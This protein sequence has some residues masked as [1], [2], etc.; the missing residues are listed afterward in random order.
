MKKITLLLLAAMLLPIT[1][2][3]TYGQNNKVDKLVVSSTPIKN[4]SEAPNPPQFWPSAEEVQIEDFY[5]AIQSEYGEQAAIYYML[6]PATPPTSATTVRTNGTRCDGGSGY[7]LVMVKGP[8][9]HTI[10]AVTEVNGALSE[11]A[12]ITYNTYAIGDWHLVTNNQELFVDHYE[13]IIINDEYDKAVGS[14]DAANRCFNAV[15]CEGNVIFD[16]TPTKETATVN[17]SDVKIFRMEYDH[18]TGDW[19]EGYLKDTEG[20]YYC[21]VGPLADPTDDSPIPG[22]ENQ[23]DFVWMYNGGHTGYVYLENNNADI[24][25]NTAD[26]V[27][28]SHNWNYPQDDHH[29]R[30]RLYYR[31]QGV[32]LAFMEAGQRGYYYTISDELLAVKCVTDDNNNAYLFCKDDGPSISATENTNDYEDY[33]V[34][35]TDFSGDWDQSNWIGL[36]FNNVNDNELA[37]IKDCE[38]KRLKA[39]TITVFHRRTYSYNSN[40]FVYDMKLSKLET[41]SDQVTAYNPNLYCPANFLTSNLEGNAT[42]SGSYADTHYFFMNPKLQE[43]CEV[44]FAVWDGNN[45]VLPA[46]DGTN[47][48]TGIQGALL[49]NFMF[50]KMNVEDPTTGETHSLYDDLVVGQAYRFQAIVQRSTSQ[51]GVGFKEDTV[52]PGEYDP[53]PYYTVYPFNFDPRDEESIITAV[54]N[55]NAGNGVVKSVKYVSVAGVVSN[56][57]FQGVNIMVTEYTDGSRTTTKILSK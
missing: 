9:P 35:N 11:I 40:N 32:P 5:V 48:L 14:Y 51:Y 27:F 55:I 24:S 57:P 50:N 21:P 52:T 39:N 38:G 30:V 7:G 13:Y 19:R 42:G 15:A 46:P 22:I 25:Y 28:D 2:N 1:M 45:F 6:N 20:N 12:S 18:G 17:S 31:S 49:P 37:K 3:K 47:N 43:Y 36:I 10:Y 53:D 34:A 23:K 29:T 26:D 56:T 44:T 8:G 16:P 41:A 33:V 54:G 4:E